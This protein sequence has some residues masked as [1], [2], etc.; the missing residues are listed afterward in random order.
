MRQVLLKSNIFPVGKNCTVSSPTSSSSDP[1]EQLRNLSNGDPLPALPHTECELTLG[2]VCEPALRIFSLPW[3]WE[4][5]MKEVNQT[6]DISVILPNSLSKHYLK[7][8]ISLP[9]VGHLWAVKCAS[10][11]EEMWLDPKW[12]SMFC[13]NPSIELWGS[14]ST[15]G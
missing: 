3:V 12:C 9:I 4:P 8:D 2:K 11:S 14:A 7:D 6:T 10:W 1:L 5:G 13:S 15:T